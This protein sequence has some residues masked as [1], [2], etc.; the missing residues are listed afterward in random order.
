MELAGVEAEP[1]P[2]A[3]WPGARCTRDFCAIAL[4]REG[5]EWHVLL[6]RSDNLIEERA[7]AAAC[8]RSDIVVADRYLP[9]ACTPRFLL[10]DRRMLDVTGGLAI[11][12]GEDALDVT[13]V[14]ETQGDHGW[15]RGRRE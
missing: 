13:T 12:L 1:I 10:G 5:R 8:E 11:V 9:R 15:W 7:L 14:S 3:Q 4:E 2:L 6:A